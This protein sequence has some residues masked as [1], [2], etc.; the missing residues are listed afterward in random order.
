MGPLSPLH[1][2]EDCPSPYTGP[3][4]TPRSVNTLTPI[5]HSGFLS[6]PGHPTLM[7]SPGNTLSAVT[8]VGHCL[9]LCFKG[10]CS[11]TQSWSSTHGDSSHLSIKWQQQTWEPGSASSAPL[12]ASGESEVVVVEAAGRLTCQQPGSC[13]GG[14][15]LCSL[16]LRC[17]LPLPTFQNEAGSAAGN[18]S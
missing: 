15:H 5:E 16:T 14:S 8:C 4:G 9:R 2:P 3:C 18:F 17:S 12:L 10:P 6:C 13:C 7:T 1:S 11:Q